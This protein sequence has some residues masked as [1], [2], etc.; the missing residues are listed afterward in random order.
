MNTVRM[1]ALLSVCVCAGP[2]C[3][4]SFS[5]A[6]FSSTAG[7]N[8]LGN[9]A[10]SGTDLRL[11]PALE[12]QSA[13]VWHD[14]KSLVMHGFSAGFQFRLTEPGGVP[15]FFGFLGADGLAFVIQ[16]DTATSIG[17]GGSGMCYEGIPN[18]I[19]VEF[20]T[21]GHPFFGDPDSNHISVQTMGLLPNTYTPAASI[22]LASAIPELS[23]GAVLTGEVA[24]TPG[25]LTVRLD[26]VEVLSVTVNLHTLLSLDGGRAWVGFTSSTGG[27]WQNH[28]LLSWSFTE[29]CYPDCN[30]GGN[31]TIADFICF[32]GAFVAG[33]LPYAD[34]NGSGTLTI[35]DFICFQGEFVAGCN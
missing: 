26:G 28:D 32:Q 23:S 25:T 16:N 11:T 13:A 24:Y 6:N 21:W 31:L 10:V 29:A 9:A 8:L 18:C 14:A 2:A 22:G 1:G 5:Y 30:S 19:A 27:A 35:A 7:L 15:D 34:C 4:Q 20:D 3:A 17:A 12:G 33:S